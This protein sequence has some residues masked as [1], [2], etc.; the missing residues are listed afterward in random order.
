MKFQENILIY[1]LMIMVKSFLKNN[2]NV[3]IKDS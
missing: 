1:I 2:Q 3:V